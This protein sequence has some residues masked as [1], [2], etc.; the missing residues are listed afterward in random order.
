MSY[1]KRYISLILCIAVFVSCFCVSAG[2]AQIETENDTGLLHFDLL[3]A[4][5]YSFILNNREI[6]ESTPAHYFTSS[7]NVD[8][9]SIKWESGHNRNFSKVIV[10]LNSTKKPAAVR[11]EGRELTFINKIDYS[12]VNDVYF[13]ELP[14]PTPFGIDLELDVEFSEIY[15]GFF[16]VYSIVGLLDTAQSIKNLDI[17]RE[18]YFLVTEGYE[19]TE[20]DPIK[21]KTLPYTFSKFD[22]ESGYYR[23]QFR[24]IVDGDV[25]VTPLVDHASFLFTTCCSTISHHVSLISK[26]SNGSDVN[27]LKYNLSEFFEWGASGDYFQGYGEFQY[28]KTFQIDVDLSGFDMSKFDLMVSVGVDT[29]TETNGFDPCYADL[30]LRSVSYVPFVENVPW[31]KTFFGSLFVGISN[32]FNTIYGTI[33]TFW[34]SVT[35]NFDLLF[36]KLEE[37]FGNDGELAEAGDQMQQQA[38]E[39]QQANEYLDSVDRPDVSADLL[40]DGYLSFNSNSLAILS[41]FSSNA[42]VTQLLVV[43]FT[44]ALTAFVFFGK[45]K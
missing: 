29:I 25:F 22:E 44:F 23:S 10:A 31:Y 43:V 45:R 2:A 8:L 14:S 20:A 13:Y 5:E 41:V 21:N 28:Y 36:V 37:Y 19:F 30:S 39:M 34:Q 7:N 15:T 40:L 33:D 6:M 11:F 42:Y 4:T 38:G 16:G 26:N 17:Y 12:L 9:I 27:N 24:F 32:W 3:Q 18:D 35:G 1:I